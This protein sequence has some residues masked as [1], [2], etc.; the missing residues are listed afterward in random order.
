MRDLYEPLKTPR[1]DLREPEPAHAPLMF[2]AFSS[3][4]E[5]TR[6]LRWRPHRQIQEAQAAMTQRLE[7]LRET[8]EFSWVVFQRASSSVV[9]VVSLWPSP[10]AA[11][12]G[13][14]FSRGAWGQGIAA[15]AAGAVLYWAFQ[16]LG[17]ERVWAASDLEN[18][19][20]RRVLEKLGMVEE[21]I[22]P[23]FAVHPN[24][25]SEPRDCIVY[26]ALRSAA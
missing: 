16:R 13:F 21:R 9:G 23:A 17:L 25:S 20:S 19:R 7:R 14:A 1:L 11:E 26:A 15:E 12:L 18:T 5:V 24:I 6:F 4:P 3:D 10:P 8:S 2:A 22:A